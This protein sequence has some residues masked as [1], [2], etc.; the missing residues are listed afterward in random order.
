M[1]AK[2]SMLN[3]TDLGKT[4]NVLVGG[5]AA[6]LARSCETICRAPSKISLAGKKLQVRHLIDVLAFLHLSIAHVVAAVKAKKHS[7][8]YNH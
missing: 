5:S 6:L 1:V 3:A 2:H 4:P 8:A 7:L